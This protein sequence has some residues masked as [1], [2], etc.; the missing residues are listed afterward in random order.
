MKYYKSVYNENTSK[1]ESVAVDSPEDASRCFI[2]D[3][4]LEKAKIVK[5]DS[6]QY[7][8]DNA[9][10]VQYKAKIGFSGNIVNSSNGN[11]VVIHKNAPKE[12]EVYDLDAF[13]ATS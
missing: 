4:I 9:K 7:D 8:V 11:G 13:L 10:L 5:N 1:N 6:G 3:K 2:G 12:D